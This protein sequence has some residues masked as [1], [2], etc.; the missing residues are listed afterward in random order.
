M[1]GLFAAALVLA[2]TTASAAERWELQSNFWVNLHQTLLAAS[3]HDADLPLTDAERGS[4]TASVTAYRLR[5]GDRLPFADDD[6]TRIN[7]TLSNAG[8]GV[9]DSVG[10]ELAAV[11]NAAAPLYRRKMWPADDRA[12]RFWISAARGL[13]AETSGDLAAEHSRVYG[14]PFPA[15]VRVDVTP[16]AGEFGAYTTASNGFVHTT[17]SSRDPGYQGFAALEML[18]HEASHAIAGAT[19]GAIGPD[20]QSN[21]QKAGVLA[22]RQLW[23]AVIFY[24]SGE[25]TRRAL[26]AR[27]VSEYQP[28]AE[29]QQMYD[30]AF[31]GLQRPL[32]T[33]WQAFL[34]GT[35]S[36]ADAL[37]NLVNA[38]G[39]PPI[40]RV[41]G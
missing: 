25:L 11:L 3:Q 7:D 14:T 34:N 20:I 22:P 36:R 24:T 38:T 9:P 5:F 35:L 39:I 26:R 41:P 4:W 10:P 30:R 21:A 23:H 15:R 33:Y 31:R 18:F 32:E 16:F 28:Y 37:A 13:L 12:N 2:A 1:K 19:N 17:V 29:R 8:E 6:L 40:P 27:G